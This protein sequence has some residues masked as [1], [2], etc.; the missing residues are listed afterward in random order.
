MQGRR[1]GSKAP[2]DFARTKLP[3]LTI[4]TEKIRKV[5][6]W[7]KIEKKIRQVKCWPMGGKMLT[8]EI[9]LAK[10]WRLN[11]TLNFYNPALKYTY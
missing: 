5:N 6:H 9:E 7:D 8:K 4:K 2:P 1:K 11:F 10:I 3:N